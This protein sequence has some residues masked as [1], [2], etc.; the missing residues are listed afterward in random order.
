MK[1]IGCLGLVLVCG[2]VLSGCSSNADTSKLEEKLDKITKNVDTLHEKV[3][4]LSE[5]GL[6]AGDSDSSEKETEE[7]TKESKESKKT[8]ASSETKESKA[9]S[10]PAGDGKGVKNVAVKAE[11]LTITITDVDFLGNMSEYSDAEGLVVIKYSIENTGSESYDA[12]YVYT[13]VYVA[14]DDDDSESSL[15]TSY[16][17][18]EYDEYADLYKKSSSKVKAGG[19][20]E[21]VLAYEITDLSKNVVIKVGADDYFAYSGEDADA[22]EVFTSEAIKKDIKSN[23]KIVP[24]Y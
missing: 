19:K 12:T 1:K 16:E 4:G 14:E 24:N 9:K 8:E 7:S 11:S 10:E 17:I 20:L 21:G 15:E 6:V 18:D 23:E 2:L 5:N 22:S 3:D 13:H